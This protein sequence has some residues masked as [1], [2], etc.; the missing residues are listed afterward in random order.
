MVRL[1]RHP[2]VAAQQTMIN[3]QE[4]D[5]NYRSLRRLGVVTRYCG[6][7]IDLSFNFKSPVQLDSTSCSWSNIIDANYAK[8]I[9][10]IQHRLVLNESRNLNLLEK[11]WILNTF[12]LS[13]LWYIAQVFPPRNYHLSKIKS[14]VGNF[15]WR[16]AVFRV[17][18]E[19]LY[20]DNDKGGLRLVDPES[21]C[22][23][24]FVKSL[25]SNSTDDG[26]GEEEYLLQYGN[27]GQLTRNGKEW[28]E[29]AQNIRGNNWS[30]TSSLLYN[31]FINRLEIQP[32]PEK[33]HPEIDWITLWK[34]LSWNFLCSEDKTNIYLLYN[35]VIPN[36]EKLE[37]FGIGRLPSI[38]CEYC[39]VPDNNFHRVVECGKVEDI[40]QWTADVIRNRLKLNF[41]KLNDILSWNI[42]EDNPRQK[43]A[44]WL[45]VHS[46]SYSITRRE[47]GS[48][49][50]F[51]KGIRALRWAN[52]RTFERH[53]KGFLN[54]C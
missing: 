52:R 42:S 5:E 4:L 44:L 29:M 25:L 32:K 23:A 37:A 9:R 45:A 46:V 33:D 15:L 2:S 3:L 41:S 10:N 47:S 34:N 11:V 35:D 12:M 30:Q 20:L 49:F 38:V 8:L 21:K 24:L 1:D 14:M 53:F 13:K 19:Q 43:A 26:A 54:V 39:G 28:V 48:L 7:I 17:S 22:K 36:K 27:K 51:K 40:R 31:Y 6:K 18:R 16:G 50:C